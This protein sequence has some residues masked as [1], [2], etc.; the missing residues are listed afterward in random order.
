M[1][2]TW[3]PCSSYRIR[4]LCAGLHSFVLDWWRPFRRPASLCIVQSFLCA[5]STPKLHDNPFLT[6][7]LRKRVLKTLLIPS[8]DHMLHLGLRCC[9][10]GVAQR[11]GM[12]LS[13]EYL[14]K[15]GYAGSCVAR[16][17]HFQTVLAF[18][19]RWNLPLSASTLG[20]RVTGLLA[21]RG[22]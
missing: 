15:Q 4:V 19:G 2:G 16:M 9:I 6:Q 5:V 14:S 17:G 12:E 22:N 8:G 7:Q 13:W 1:R 18:L 20:N 3:I 10:L 21:E 11:G